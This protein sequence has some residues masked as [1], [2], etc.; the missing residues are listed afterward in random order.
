MSS[1]DIDFNAI[2]LHRGTRSDAFEELCCQL[3]AD[4]A[5]TLGAR[6]IRKGR[7]ADAGVEAFAVL[8]SGEEIGWQVKYYWKIE[9]ALAS[10]SDSLAAALAKHPSMERF[11]ACLPFDL[12]DGRKPN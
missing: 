1:P 2:R 12:A 11:V 7:G 4:E 6:F 8:P 9:D 10:L 3:A 5:K